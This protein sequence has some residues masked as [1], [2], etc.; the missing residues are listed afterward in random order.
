MAWIG[1]IVMGKREPLQHYLELQYPFRVDADPDGGYAIE[2]PDLPGCLTQADTPDEI[3]PMAE[4][5]R[6]LWI[7]TEYDAGKDVPLPSYPTEYSGKFNLRVP[8]SLH[9][10]LARSAELEGVSLNQYVVM[11]LAAGEAKTEATRPVPGA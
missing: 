4:E 7:E 2:F 11:L 1:Q 10:N 5:A 9:A 6:S 3:G 8:K